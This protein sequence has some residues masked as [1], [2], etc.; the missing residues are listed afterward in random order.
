MKLQIMAFV[1]ACG[2]AGS[3][4]AQVAEV[5]VSYAD[6]YQQTSDAAPTYQGSFFAARLM[7]FNPGDFASATLT[8]G[9][10]GSPQTLL[11]TAPTTL[12][13]Q[14]GFYPSQAALDAD[15][16]AGSY[17]FDT[18]GP[19]VALTVGDTPFPPAPQF[20]NLTELSSINP[21]QAFDLQLSAGFTPD[22]GVTSAFTF[23]TIIDDTTNTTVVN[24]GFASPAQTSFLIG[25][26]T[27]TAGDN[28]SM[29]AVFSSRFDGTDDNGSGI[30]T[31]QLF[32][33]HTEADFSVPAAAVP[34][35]GAWALMILGFGGA[36][37]ALRRRRLQAA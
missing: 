37:V 28:Y 31:T 16:P 7:M 33:E 9:G 18:G 26:N 36:G 35:P 19:T 12:T 4:L 27:F 2:V 6:Q 29:E 3:A 11:P 8:Y 5:D 13:Y 20:A 24:D 15:F 32:D 21:N 14:T 10:G 1:A 34:E 17:A 30:Q 23:I 25:A 22:A